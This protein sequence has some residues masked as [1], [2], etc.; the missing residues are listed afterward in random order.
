[1]PIS[2]NI[3]KQ[4][5]VAV[6]GA[7]FPLGDAAYEKVIN[8]DF[9]FVGIRAYYPGSVVNPQQV[10]M[11][12]MLAANDPI[13]PSGINH[14]VSNGHRGYYRSI[15]DPTKW[16]CPFCGF[17]AEF[18]VP[19]GGN[20]YAQD[21]SGTATS[22]DGEP[23]YFQIDGYAT[24]L[25]PNDS[26]DFPGTFTGPAPIIVGVDS[27]V[28]DDELEEGEAT[29]SFTYAGP[30]VPTG[31]VVEYSYDG[32]NWGPDNV[33]PYDGGTNYTTVSHFFNLPDEYWIRITPYDLDPN[34]IGEP[35]EPFLLTIPEEPGTIIITGDGGIDFGGSAT[36]IFQGD[37]S[38]IYSLIP[39]KRNDTVYDHNVDPVTTENVAIP[40]PFIK[41][42]FL[43]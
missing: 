22:V 12:P 4:T 18:V 8:P 1:M 3:Y 33:I 30:E 29:L 11:N 24:G 15:P 16:S 10:I 28:W 39:D 13:A 34:E 31:F 7:G 41:T 23:L 38:G 36:I 25:D 2:G 6:M 37:P 42:G 20:I 19:D 32:I 35:S 27:I 5:T 21:F 43:S 26:A 17:T 9:V 14:S 40:K